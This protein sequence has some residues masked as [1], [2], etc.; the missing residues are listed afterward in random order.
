MSKLIERVLNGE[1]IEKVL[2]EIRNTGLDFTT[3]VRLASI[4]E[5]AELDYINKDTLRHTKGNMH[6]EIQAASTDTD[7]I[8]KEYDK[9]TFLIDKYAYLVS[10]RVFDD[11]A[12]ENNLDTN[13]IKNRFDKISLNG[14]EFWGYI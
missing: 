7:R 10:G 8:E 13:I 6:S 2:N 9:I 12:T 1:N 11:Y 3:Y 4:K 14:K 5:L